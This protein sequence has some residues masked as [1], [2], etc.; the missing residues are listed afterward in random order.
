MTE[1]EVPV[2]KVIT[3][4]VPVTSKEDTELIIQLKNNEK[5]LKLEV[6]RL[7]RELEGNDE[8]WEKRVDVLKRK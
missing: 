4:Y 8:V 6:A 2:V 3:N 7:R 1:K 5:E